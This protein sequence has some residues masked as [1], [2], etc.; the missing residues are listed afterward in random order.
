MYADGFHITSYGFVNAVRL[1]SS[2]FI[3]LTSSLSACYINVATTV[4]Y[5]LHSHDILA[6][7]FGSALPGNTLCKEIQNGFYGNAV[8]TRDTSCC[9]RLATFCGD[10]LLSFSS[11]LPDYWTRNSRTGRSAAQ[12][13]PEVL[14]NE[15]SVTDN[16]GI[17]VSCPVIEG[18]CLLSAAARTVYNP[19][20]FFLSSCWLLI[21][22]CAQAPPS[23]I[24]WC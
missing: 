8:S 12:R 21:C 13:W 10:S 23:K 14:H 15:V 20:A 9:I 19:T 7:S 3:V 17:G 5:F 18:N 22:T 24:K 6:N 16:W 1:Q 4:P 2:F 11:A